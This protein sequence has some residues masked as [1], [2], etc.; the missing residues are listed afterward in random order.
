[1]LSADFID[2]LGI[3]AKSIKVLDKDGEMLFDADGIGAADKGGTVT[4]AG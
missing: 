4:L 1:M 2:A 3:T